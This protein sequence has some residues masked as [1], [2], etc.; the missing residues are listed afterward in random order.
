M[1]LLTIVQTVND[2][3]SLV[4]RNIE[5]VTGSTDRIVKQI[6]AI[7]KRVIYD[8]ATRFEWAELER[9]AT[10]TTVLDQETYALPYDFDRMISRT[11]WNSSESREISG[12]ITSQEYEY[13]T[14]GIAVAGPYQRYRVAGYSLKELFISPAPEGGEELTF[15]YISGNYILPGK[16]VT[17]TAYSA[18]DKV[19]YDGNIYTAQNTNTAGATAPVHTTGTTSDGGV[20][21]AFYEGASGPIQTWADDADCSVIDEQLV[22]LGT[23]SQFMYVKGMQNAKYEA[24]YQTALK[25]RTASRKGAPDLSLLGRSD[26]LLIGPWNLPDTGYGGV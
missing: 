13:R 9:K 5:T 19:S 18:A 11:F 21:W 12:P 1:S 23:I 8:L 15:K 22:I 14:E 24:M 3:L 4:A 20:S 16:W 25:R 17:G 2:E 6:K 26:P 10:I 7:S